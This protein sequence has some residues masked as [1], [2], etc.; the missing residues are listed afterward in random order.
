MTY[1]INIPIFQ[2]TMLETREPGSHLFQADTLQYKVTMNT[3]TLQSLHMKIQPVPGM[4]SFV[5]AVNWGILAA[6][7]N[8]TTFTIE[9]I[10]AS[11]GG[12]TQDRQLSRPALN[13]LSYWG[14]PS[15]KYNSWHYIDR[16][17]SGCCF[18]ELV[19]MPLFQQS[20]A[21]TTYET[22]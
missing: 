20:T 13:Q 17:C 6:V 21:I 7:C 16:G 19:P 2:L 5:D 10:L 18:K 1:D 8:G 12:R 22:F 15:S 4:S 14:I 9:K 3:S 11:G